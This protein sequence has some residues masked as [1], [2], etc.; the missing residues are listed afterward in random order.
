MKPTPKSATG[1]L[2]LKP[3]PQPKPATGTLQSQPEPTGTNDYETASIASADSDG[4]MTDDDRHAKVA[5]NEIY[6]KF[7]KHYA[8]HLKDWTHNMVD[9][10]KP[11]GKA[12]VLLEHTNELVDL[13]ETLQHVVE[14]Q[15]HLLQEQYAN[16]TATGYNM[17]HPAPSVVTAPTSTRV[18]TTANSMANSVAPGPAYPDF[19][20]ILQQALQPQAAIT[21][22]AIANSRP[23]IPRNK[24]S[25]RS[26]QQHSPRRHTGNGTWRQWKY[27]CYTCGVN[28]KHNSDGCTQRRIATTLPS[29]VQLKIIPR[30]AIL[31]EITCGCNGA[32]P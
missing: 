23:P 2:Q 20:G 5:T 14:N 13:C 32:T 18:S 8:K 24:H 26:T 17:Y 16:R 28:L 1:T 6:E 27:W 12:N 21:E 4:S 19:E 3:T 25:S 10:T 22:K 15:N 11:A 31:P 7:K 30:A 9:P 29:Q